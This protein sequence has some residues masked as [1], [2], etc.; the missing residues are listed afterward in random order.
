MRHLAAHTI[1][2]LLLTALLWQSCATS[3]RVVVETHKMPDTLRVGTLYSPTSFFLYRGDTLGYDYDRVCDF[4]KA[5]KIK[6]Q[7]KVAPNM[8][9]LIDM[10]KTKKVDLLV[11][12]IPVTAEFNE[13]VLHCGETNTTYQVLVQPKSRRRISNV[14]QLVGKTIYVEKGSK[15]ESRLRN[16]DSEIGGGIDIHTVESDTVNVENLIEGVNN[17][18][19]PLTLADNDI[20]KID[21]SYYNNID[22][23]LDVSFPQRSSWAVNLNDD[24]LADTID[25]WS[26]SERTMLYTEDIANRYFEQNRTSSSSG[27]S[28][29]AAGGKNYVKHSGDISAYDELFKKYARRC[30]YDWLLLAAI[31]RTESDFSPNEVSWAGAR[32]LM[33]IMPS[34]ARSLGIDPERLFD[35][36]VNVQCAVSE[37][38]YLDRYFSK[39]VSNSQERMK[40]VLAAYNG[41]MSHIVDAIRL[42]QKYGKDAQDVLN[43][44]LDSYADLGIYEIENISILWLP[45]FEKFGKPSKIASYF[46][47]KQGYLAAVRELEQTLYEVAV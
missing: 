27:S 3:P 25:A 35:P 4:A 14:T 6:L 38:N 11:Y 30:P 32:G 2:L 39:Y 10:I 22:I 43:T 16:L 34:G 5:K 19:I 21:K 26:T 36:E 7:F 18:T 15:Y 33:Q 37:L 12:E 40:F 41:G 31:A 46:G 13:E 29:S 28:A 17:G 42:A 23:G 44:L 9:T 8:H 1:L 24:W 20:A 47:G 45:Q